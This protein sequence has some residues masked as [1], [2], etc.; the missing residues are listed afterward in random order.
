[1]TNAEQAQKIDMLRMKV[2][3][4][5]GRLRHYPKPLLPEMREQAASVVEEYLARDDERSVRA[6]QLLQKFEA[7]IEAAS[8][9]DAKLMVM[10][11]YGDLAIGLLRAQH[12]HTA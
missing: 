12:G 9:P 2:V 4:I 10:A 11:N 5:I 8:T 3:S 6:V 7:A 1:M